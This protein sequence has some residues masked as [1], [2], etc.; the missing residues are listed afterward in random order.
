MGDK[1]RILSQARL[2]LI[3]KLGELTGESRIYESPAWG[4]TADET[5]LNQVLIVET[6][7][8]PLTVLDVIQSIE[9]HL[10][11][12]HTTPHPGS[13]PRSYESRLIDI[14]ILFYDDR[15]IHED[16]LRVPH[17]LI[18]ERDF[19]LNPLKEVMPDYIHPVY[20]RPIKEL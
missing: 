17:P 10:G 3:E 15:I 13:G 14:D 1:R 4:F 18:A 8:P 7:L 9:T 16:R 19:V 20:L 5:F 2:L 12:V 6:Y 11:R